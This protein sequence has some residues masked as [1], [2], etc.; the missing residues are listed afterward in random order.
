MSNGLKRFL[1]SAIFRAN[2]P[3]ITNHQMTVQVPTSSLD[4]LGDTVYNFNFLT[5]RT[6][7][8]AYGTFVCLSVW[9]FDC[10]ACIVAK[11][12]VV[13]VGHGRSSYRLSIVIMYLSFAVWQLFLMLSICLHPSS[14]S[15]QLPYPSVDCSVR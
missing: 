3:D 2:I 5:V 4:F 12:Y 6:Y 13:R 8:R 14:I 15:V 9:L 7:D 1:I 10:K 11:R